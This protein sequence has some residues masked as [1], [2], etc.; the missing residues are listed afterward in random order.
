MAQQPLNPQPDCLDFELLP[1]TPL[2]P[3]AG[4]VRLYADATSGDLAAIKA[5]GT[6]A[7]PNTAP[8]GAAGDIQFNLGDGTFT[9]AAGIN[10]SSQAS[11]SGGGNMTFAAA[12]GSIAFVANNQ[13]TAGANK[14]LFNAG[15]DVTLELDSTTNPETFTLDSDL[16]NTIHKIAPS[17]GQVLNVGN[18]SG[19]KLGFYGATAVVKPTITG[20]KAGNTAV[21]GI[22]AVLVALGL[23]T[24]GTT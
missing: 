2:V 22:V 19:F 20:A 15:G 8:G 7:L 21:A 9:N 17:A 23:A 16:S 6:S 13:Y 18:A 4:S 3:N 10:A 11:L 5:D 12:A 14:I 1:A 24:D